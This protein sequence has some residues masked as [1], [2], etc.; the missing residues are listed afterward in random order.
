MGGGGHKKLGCVISL[1]VE[2]GLKYLLYRGK[3]KIPSEIELIINWSGSV[4]LVL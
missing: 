2:F 3:E 4:R 1:V